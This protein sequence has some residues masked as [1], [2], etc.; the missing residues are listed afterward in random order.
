LLIHSA[1]KRPFCQPAQQKERMDRPFTHGFRT[2]DIIRAVVPSH[3]KNAGTHVGRMSAKSSGDFTIATAKGTI[4]DIGKKYCRLLQR[5]DGYGYTQKGE[6][7]FPLT[8]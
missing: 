2:G 6:V 5:A 1:G 8:T 3:L 4:T 7:A